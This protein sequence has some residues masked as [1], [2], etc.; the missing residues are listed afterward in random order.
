M[1]TLKITLQYNIYCFAFPLYSVALLCVYLHQIPI[2]LCIHISVYVC[3]CMSFCINT[4]MQTD[5]QNDT[6]T[7]A[8]VFICVLIN[9]C[10]SWK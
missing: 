9:A 6:H 3:V 7:H 2:P 5:K 1:F 8:R 4:F 10:V